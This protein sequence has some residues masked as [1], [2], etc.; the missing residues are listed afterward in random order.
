ML[1]TGNKRTET[2]AHD[3]YLETKRP[4]SHYFNNGLSKEI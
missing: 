3:V 1:S 4:Y 2:E